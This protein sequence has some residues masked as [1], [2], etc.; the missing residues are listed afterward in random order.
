[1]DK[2]VKVIIE[3]DGKYLLIRRDDDEKK[4]HRG[5]WECP[6]GKLEKEESFEEAA[7]REVKEETNLNIILKKVVKKI[8]K[9]NEV[10]AVVFLAKPKNA[11]LKIS[12][13]H[14][15]FGWFTYEELKN[16]EPIT[17]KDFF[18]ELMDLS[19]EN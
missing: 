11:N 3:K 8:E 19:R 9:E 15:D 14:N 4:G 17:Y 16:L 7:I 2:Q 12:K 13:E 1:M 6:G 5:N 18:L 10:R